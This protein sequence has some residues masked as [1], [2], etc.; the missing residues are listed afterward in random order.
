MEL[1][2]S[3]MNL[4]LRIYKSGVRSNYMQLKADSENLNDDVLGKF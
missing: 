4:K 1:S 2:Y 3:H